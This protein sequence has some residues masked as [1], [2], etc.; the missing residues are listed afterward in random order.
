MMNPLLL[1]VIVAV[2]API[3]GFAILRKE[4]VTTAWA[5]GVAAIGIGVMAAVMLILVLLG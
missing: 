5:I 1:F 4:A 2:G 3:V